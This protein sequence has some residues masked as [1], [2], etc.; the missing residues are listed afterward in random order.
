M[1]EGEEEDVMQAWQDALAAEAGP[2]AYDDVGAQGQTYLQMV[3][4]A[5]QP[6]CSHSSLLLICFAQPILGASLYRGHAFLA[7][8]DMKVKGSIQAMLLPKQ[9]CPCCVSVR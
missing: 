2:V 8:L 4:S 9:I 5:S 6:G 3:H 1:E 7:L